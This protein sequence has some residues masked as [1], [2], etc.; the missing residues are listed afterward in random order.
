MH[1]EQGPGPNKGQRVID[2]QFGLEIVHRASLLRELMS[3]IPKNKLHVGK[4]LANLDQ[5][6]A[7]TATLHFEDGTS[8]DANVVIGADGIHSSVRKYLLGEGSVYRW[9]IRHCPDCPVD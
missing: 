1:I 9:T 4:R 2:Q 8:A 5:Q 3:T 6:N 7:Y